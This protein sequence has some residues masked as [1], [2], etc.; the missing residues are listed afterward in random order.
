MKRIL[1]LALT[2][3]T[4]S[5]WAQTLNPVSLEQLVNTDVASDQYCL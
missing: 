2:L 1:F 4:V 3:I 5:I